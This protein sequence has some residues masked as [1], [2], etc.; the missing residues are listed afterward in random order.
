MSGYFTMPSPVFSQTQ[1]CDDLMDDQ[2]GDLRNQRPQPPA[3]ATRSLRDLYVER[4]DL[5]GR[6]IRIVRPAMEFPSGIYRRVLP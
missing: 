4:E 6:H 5:G 3:V 1:S 2:A